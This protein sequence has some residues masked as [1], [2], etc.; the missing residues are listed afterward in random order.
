MAQVCRACCKMELGQKHRGKRGGKPSGWRH[1]TVIKAM[2]NLK[3]AHW[4]NRLTQPHTKA[5]QRGVPISGHQD[6]LSC[7]LL[8]YKKLSS[9][10]TIYETH[11]KEKNNPLS[12]DKADIRTRSKNA[13]LPCHLAGGI[14]LLHGLL[15]S[16]WPHVLLHSLAWT[17]RV[18]LRL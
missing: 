13:H 15:T 10:V 8:F 9:S 11:N 16:T 3:P 1:L 6:Y 4:L 5:C 2:T 18:L 17:P 7:S 14:Q 12:R